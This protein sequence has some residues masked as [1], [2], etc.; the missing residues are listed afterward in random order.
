MCSLREVTCQMRVNCQGEILATPTEKWQFCWGHNCFLLFLCWKKK[1]AASNR[2]IL[3]RK[4]SP[5]RGGW[6]SCKITSM[7]IWVEASIKRKAG[8]TRLRASCKLLSSISSWAIMGSV[9]VDSTAYLLLSSD[10]DYLPFIDDNGC[11]I[12][13][14]PLQ[15]MNKPG[16]VHQTTI[17]CSAF[18]QTLVTQQI[19]QIFKIFFLLYLLP[20][21]F[22][23]C[24][25][26]LTAAIMRRRNSFIMI[27]LLYY[28][29]Y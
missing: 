3:Y 4:G 27:L 6:R 11:T 2:H 23:L 26:Y 17:T 12:D 29:K 13:E 22:V 7:Y 5:W 18:V 20:I 15:R 25:K 9:K 14:F 10:H 24:I 28:L 8:T 21:I 19:H 1:P 16:E